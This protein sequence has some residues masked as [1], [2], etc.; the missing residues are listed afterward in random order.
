MAQKMLALTCECCPLPHHSVSQP[1]D[2]DFSW[3]ITLHVEWTTG[4][5]LTCVVQINFV[6]AYKNIKIEILLQLQTF[7][8]LRSG[9][10]TRTTLSLLLVPVII[11]TLFKW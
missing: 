8:R 2:K 6:T 10:Y 1:L 11:V 4:D 9:L 3:I 7:H 5:R